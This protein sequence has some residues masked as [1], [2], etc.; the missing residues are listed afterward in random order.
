MKSSLLLKKGIMPLILA[1]A[2]GCGSAQV[3]TELPELSKTV[4]ET[5]KTEEVKDQRTITEIAQSVFDA[6]Q[7]NPSQSMISLGDLSNYVQNKLFAYIYAATTPPE[8]T[9][10]MLAYRIQPGSKGINLVFID[11]DKPD[12]KSPFGVLD[13]VDCIP[14]EHYYCQQFGLLSFD[15]EVRKYT[16]G[17]LSD[18]YENLIRHSEKHLKGEIDLK[19]EENIKQN[20]QKLFYLLE[21]AEETS[22]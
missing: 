20:F 19:A 17:L 3:K 14:E 5:R 10:P 21:P 11:I 16:A 9:Y 4:K 15:P 7:K 6:E 13:T 8:T 12:S 22:K 18:T 2:A 1:A